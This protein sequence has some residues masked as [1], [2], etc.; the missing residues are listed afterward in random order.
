MW[1]KT[2]KMRTS[3][4]S[5]I[6]QIMTDHRQ[7]KNVEYFNYFNSMIINDTRSSTCEIKSRTAIAKVTFNKKTLF[8]SKLDFG[9]RKKLMKCYIWRITLY[10]AETWA[11]QYVDQK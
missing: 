8:T 3:R 2:K 10:G 9:L 4:P 6:V 5:S 1:E 7:L 11:F